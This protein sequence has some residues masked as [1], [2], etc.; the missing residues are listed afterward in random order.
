[1]ELADLATEKEIKTWVFDLWAK[2]KLNWHG[3]APPSN[4]RANI[5]KELARKKPTFA[6]LAEIERSIEEQTRFWQKKFDGKK[7]YG[8][9]T[10][11]QWIKDGR[12]DD[13]FIEESFTTV[14]KQQVSLCECGQ[15]V[16]GP[17]YHQCTDCLYKMTDTW[18]Q[19][20]KEVM[21]R[22]G[23]TPKPNETLSEWA[24]R[25]REYLLKQPK[26]DMILK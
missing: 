5:L 21:I 10:V 25:C 19:A 16:H 23:L 8:I 20:R 9:P 11:Q 18:K 7:S 22:L 24:I 15:P 2:G 14:G 17:M 3:M 1:M 13:E 26:L 6:M 4:S 12:Y